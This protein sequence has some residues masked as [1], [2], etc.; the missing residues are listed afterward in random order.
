VRN[1]DG[2]LIQRNTF[3]YD[4]KGNMIRDNRFDGDGSLSRYDII[5]YDNTGRRERTDEY[6]PDGTLS[7]YIL[8]RYKDDKYLGVDVYDA[9]GTLRQS[10]TD[11]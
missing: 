2:E 4:A 8:Y 5:L 11:E 9:D 3:E 7:V 1:G 10:T 6:N